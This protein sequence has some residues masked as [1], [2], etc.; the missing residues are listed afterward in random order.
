M[1]TSGMMAAVAAAAG[2]GALA[3]ENVTIDA[4]FIAQHFPDI[5]AGLKAE[6]AKAERERVLGIEKASMPGHEKIIA[7]Y[8]AD[9]TKTPADAAFAVLAAEQAARAGQLQALDKDE[10][11]MRGLRAEPANGVDPKAEREGSE[12]KPEGEPKWKADYASSGKLQKE[13][14]SEAEY[15]AY[16]RAEARGG[17]KRPKQRSA[18]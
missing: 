3:A 9:A 13:F 8:K 5:A 11:S 12:P 16:M 7:A 18:G 1:T 14:A 10:Q 6:G 15:L 4:A 17:I 2:I